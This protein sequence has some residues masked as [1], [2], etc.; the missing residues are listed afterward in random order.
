M[1]VSGVT[2]VKCTTCSVA[3]GKPVMLAL[4]IATLQCHEGNYTAEKYVKN[5]CRHLRNE[6]TLASKGVRPID[7]A[8]QDIAGEKA[9]KWQQMGMIFHL[10]TTCRPMVDFSAIRPMLQ[11]LGVPKLAKRHWSD[12]AG[13]VLAE[14]MFRHI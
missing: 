1:D 6:W 8:I 2:M 7:E 4:K 5:N 9:R 13:W 11:F 12:G 10:L 3:A 14:C